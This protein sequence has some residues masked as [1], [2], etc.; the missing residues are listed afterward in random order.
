[1]PNNY[2]NAYVLINGELYHYGVLGM[3]WGRR[4]AQARSSANER[5]L[6]KSLKYDKKAA[7][8]TLKSEKAHN[9]NDLEKANKKAVKAAKLDKKAAILNKKANG[10]DEH[11]RLRLEKKATNLEYKASKLKRSSNRLSK[12]VGYGAKAMSYSIKSDRAA[13]KA[14]KARAKIA[15][16]KAY[17]EMI[18]RKMNSLDNDKIRK[19]EQP[20]SEILKNHKRPNRKGGEN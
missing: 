13:S 14:A 10:V 18:N 7:S 9:K 3:K 5:L 2:D 17:I 15:K 4:K 8:L 6:K 1:M 12:S 16:N 19:V 20:I 11:K